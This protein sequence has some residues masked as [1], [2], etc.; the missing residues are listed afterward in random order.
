MASGA[1]R[2]E[3]E[4]EKQTVYI[5]F[6]TRICIFEKPLD[7]NTVPAELQMLA[8]CHVPG[9]CHAVTP[10][11]QSWEGAAGTAKGRA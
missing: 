6:P 5:V 4:E 2:G 8:V 7:C 1:A 9:W 3:R 10:G 11:L